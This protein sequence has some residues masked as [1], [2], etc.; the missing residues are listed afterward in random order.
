MYAVAAVLVIGI[1]FGA[2]AA[3]GGLSGRSA[4]SAIP[5]PPR[6][7]DRF[8]PD[9]NGTGADNQANI[10]AS[11]APG[12][13]HI[14]SGRG[15]A[16]GVGMILTPSGI[17]LTTDQI[18]RQAGRASV[19]I[20]LSGRPFG[21]RLIGSDGA[22]GLALLQITGGSSFRAVTVG[23]SS[24]LSAGAAVTGVGSSG[25][26]RTI[27]LEVGNLTGRHGTVAV[28]GRK[29]TGLLVTTT[30]VAAGEETGGPLVNLSGQVIGVDLA[31]A[32]QGLRSTGYAMPI[33]RALMIAQQ[34]QAAHG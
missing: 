1:G 33:N 26:A 14:V 32:G 3:A 25:T 23:N 27:T 18:W 12:L 20:V 2:F 24:L 11:T 21:A 9:D 13:V 28:S 4:S 29:L 7:N 10:L 30:R 6:S 31:G 34:I 5:V 19:R 15:T 8:V 16:A 22:S 17:V